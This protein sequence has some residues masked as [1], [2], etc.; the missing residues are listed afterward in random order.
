MCADTT[1]TDSCELMTTPADTVYISFLEESPYVQIHT[2]SFGTQDPDSHRSNYGRGF[3]G[4]EAVPTVK[5]DK[6]QRQV[7]IT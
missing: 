6:S 2:G 3:A 5:Q 1:R 4:E 7:G